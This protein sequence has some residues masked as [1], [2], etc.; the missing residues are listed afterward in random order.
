[1]ANKRRPSPSNTFSTLPE[2]RRP[3]QASARGAHDEALAPVT[4][5]RDVVIRAGETNELRFT[6]GDRVK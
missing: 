2:S 3:L 6:E 4:Y 5:N 1:L